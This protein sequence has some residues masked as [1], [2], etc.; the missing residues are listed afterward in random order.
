MIYEL[1]ASIQKVGKDWRAEAER[2]RQVAKADP[3][4]DA[5]DYCAGELEAHCA[6]LRAEC[7]TVTVEQ[8]AAAHQVSVQTVR[9]WIHSG[10]LPAEKTTRGYRV[11][12]TAVRMAKAS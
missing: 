5:L 2:R 4:A 6:L 8:Y 9:N 12:P 3:A 10:E 7:V 1:L 11:A